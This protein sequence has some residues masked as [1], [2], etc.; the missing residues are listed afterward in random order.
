MLAVIRTGGKQ[1]RVKEGDQIMVE[2]IEGKPEEK[3]SFEEVLLFDN[4]KEVKVGAPIIKG[5]KVEGKIIEQKKD[6]KKTIVRHKAKKRQLTR[7]G[8]RQEVTKVEIVKI[9]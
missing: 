5:V 8:H 1:Y 2:K 3:I 7:K 9:S 6:R 4:D